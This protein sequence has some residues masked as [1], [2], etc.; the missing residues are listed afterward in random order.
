M[1]TKLIS[2]NKFRDKEHDVT[3]WLPATNDDAWNNLPIVDCVKCHP[4]P[5]SPFNLTRLV[6]ENEIMNGTRFMFEGLIHTYPSE[7]FAKVFVGEMGKIVPDEL[8][9][10]TFGDVGCSTMPQNDKVFGTIDHS[11]EVDGICAMMVFV[12]PVPSTDTSKF[13]D[14]LM[15]AVKNVYVFGYDLSSV[16]QLNHTLMHDVT[17]FLVQMEARFSKDKFKI[18]DVFHHVAPLKYL[19]KIRK[20]GLVPKSKSS[21]FK[22]QDRVY[23]FNYCPIET[24]LTYGMQK[25]ID[26]KDEGFCLLS[27]D[28]RKLEALNKHGNLN[29]YIDWAFGSSDN[30]VAVFTYGNI[31][32]SALEDEFKVYLI[33]D[34]DNPETRRL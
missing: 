34:M 5:N 4:C 30:P 31:P 11:D 21:E 18:C 7:K 28:R 10:L 15:N 12:V 1:R 17:I 32:S 24:I 20:N 3:R 19:D 22:Y 8:K 25:A 14:R 27:L 23:L 13:K 26:E 9:K 33:D 2:T 29:L 16:E 6:Y